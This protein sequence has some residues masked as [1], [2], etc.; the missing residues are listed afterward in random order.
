MKWIGQHI[1]DFISRFRTTVYI[2]NLETS[3]EE[4][5]LVVDSDGKVTKNTTL[6]GSDVTMTNGVDNRVMTATGAAAINGEANLTFDGADIEI[7]LDD[8]AESK[9]KKKAHSD[10][11]AGQLSIIGAP[12]TAGQT[13]KRGG[14]VALYAGLGTGDSQ[15]GGIDFYMAQTGS[16]GTSLNAYEPNPAISMYSGSNV[17]IQEWYEQAGDSSSDLCSLKVGEHGA[18]TITTT[19][20]GG[21]NAN[22]QIT[23]DGTAELAG[24]AVTLDSA[25]DIEL[26]VGA[27]T[28]YINAGGIFRGGNIGVISD[29]FIPI[30]WTDFMISNSYRYPGQTALG[31]L[32]LSPASASN[33][34]YA[35]KVIPKGYTATSCVIYGLDADEGSTIACYGSGINT[36]TVNSLGTAVNFDN[37]TSPDS[38]T[39]TFSSNIVGDGLRTC[40]IEW[41][42]DD[43]VDKIYGG[44]IIIEKT[45]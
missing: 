17:T 11:H 33:N 20:G 32:G 30:V 31:G 9:I 37:A 6:G 4:N 18:T 25:G 10:D 15:N 7:G 23:A 2:E 16:S 3:S 13:D 45:T 35:V 40:Q 28:N 38:A 5:V 24:T 22:L 14:K 12:A 41:N 21:S 36:A 39:F 26:E 42:P 29:L 1:W 44:K 43:A 8:S 27:T 19:D 34:Y